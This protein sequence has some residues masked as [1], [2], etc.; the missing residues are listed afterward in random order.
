[1]TQD[2]ADRIAQIV[3][4]RDELRSLV[5]WH[6]EKHFVFADITINQKSPMH[7]QLLAVFV[8]RLKYIETELE[9]IE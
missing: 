3:K 6:Q 8:A 7:S 1:M 9:G 5:E 4:E 2:K